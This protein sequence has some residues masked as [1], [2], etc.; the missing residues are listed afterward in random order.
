MDKKL[1]VM[2]AAKL[3]GV[4]K[5]AIYNRLR[6]GTL[7]S[8]VENGT[9][10]I[11]LSKGGMKENS[12]VRKAD[13]SADYSAYVELL[14]TQLDEMKQKNQKLEEDKERLIADK[15]RM[16]IESKEKIEMIYKER[17][18]QLKAILT[19][20][21]RQ[22]THTNT[23]VHVPESTH[24]ESV[25]TS[26]VTPPMESFE[27]ADVVEEEGQKEVES[28]F[29]V[30]SDWRDLRSYLKEKGFSKKEK[31]HINDAVS[32]RVGHFDSV[33]D[34]DGKLFIKKGKKLKEIL[35]ES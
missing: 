13:M 27:E 33:M 28:L 22:I 10:Y 7:Q 12:S 21:N 5:E 6:R 16:L 4:S 31:H 1:T 20:A 18:E 30:Y 24:M 11:V 35:G 9:K 15:E 8:V 32:K 19:L 29:E 25:N 23:E 2:E 34:R 3:L 26:I 14:K 17:D